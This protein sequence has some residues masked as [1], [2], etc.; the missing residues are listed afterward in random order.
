MTTT[1]ELCRT[2]YKRYISITQARLGE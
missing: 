1:L 2:V